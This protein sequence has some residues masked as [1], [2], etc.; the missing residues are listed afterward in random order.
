MPS[1][2]DSMGSISKALVEEDLSASEAD[3][4]AGKAVAMVLMEEGFRIGKRGNDTIKKAG[5]TIKDWREYFERGRGHPAALK[6]YRLIKEK[7]RYPAGTPAAHI[8]A[9]MKVLLPMVLAG[10]FK[11]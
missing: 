2:P 3:Q 4:N 7:Y 8:K 9:E 10:R 1:Q 5:G 6:T 11:G